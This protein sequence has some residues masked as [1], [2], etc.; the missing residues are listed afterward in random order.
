MNTIAKAKI[1]VHNEYMGLFQ[2]TLGY[3]G[4]LQ[5]A[6]YKICELESDRASEIGV[7]P[8]VKTATLNEKRI[9]ECI[10]NLE[11]MLEDMSL[12]L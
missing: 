9:R 7:Q 6:T 12:E 11:N 1:E 3:E 10:A 5:Y 2:S 8:E 4:L